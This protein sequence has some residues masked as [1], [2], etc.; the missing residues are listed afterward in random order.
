MDIYTLNNT[1]P[2]I[3]LTLSQSFLRLTKDYVGP[4][5][6]NGFLI[7]TNNNTSTQVSG[8]YITNTS[9]SAYSPTYEFKCEK[10]ST[11]KYPSGN[12]C[13]IL[14]G[15]N[16]HIFSPTSLVVNSPSFH[17]NESYSGIQVYATTNPSISLISRTNSG[18]QAIRFINSNN[19]IEYSICKDSRGIVHSS[20]DQISF[21]DHFR[22][23]GNYASI[24][25]SSPNALFDNVALSINGNMRV[26]DICASTCLFCGKTRF[27]NDTGTSGSALRTGVD[28]YTIAKFYCD[29]E[30][31][32]NLISRCNICTNYLCSSTDL[33]A[34][35]GIYGCSGFF[36]N[37]IKSKC[38]IFDSICSLS[39][40]SCFSNINVS[41]ITIS[42]SA[43]TSIPCLNITN[44]L[45]YS[46]NLCF[47]NRLDT[48]GI[49]I[50]ESSGIQLKATGFNNCLIL[51][52]NLNCVKN[53]NAQGTIT[54]DNIVTT[55]L[56]NCHN[57]F[58]STIGVRGD[59]TGFD[60]ISGVNTSHLHTNT[61]CIANS[62]T[63]N[64]LTVSNSFNYNG[65]IMTACS[66]CFCGGLYAGL[67]S[68]GEIGA[69]NSSKAWGV[70]AL[71]G[72]VPLGATGYNFSDVRVPGTGMFKTPAYSA[73]NTIA[74]FTC[75]GTITCPSI[76][77]FYY[78]FYG[79]RL[80]KPVR[81]PF[82]FSSTFMNTSVTFGTAPTGIVLQTS[83]NLRYSGLYGS[84]TVANPV[85]NIMSQINLV[86]CGGFNTAGNFC[87]NDFEQ[88]TIGRCYNEIIIN[89]SPFDFVACTGAYR[90]NANTALQGF[91]NGTGMFHIV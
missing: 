39:G 81:Y 36:E 45:G 87:S 52:G 55:G 15:S 84:G 63:T 46:G 4:Y 56:F 47:S 7:A 82:A 59:I 85:D 74:H 18:Q 8:L 21:N 11:I 40:T 88:F 24:G 75:T 13:L 42:S 72:G 58:Q 79:L 28:F 43:V 67:N 60:C 17:S 80:N 12:Y 71:S 30:A 29:I 68:S 90:Y 78:F 38:G 62:I 34:I 1:A 70:F 65:N 89:I 31:D 57:Y 3:S 66:G 14:T 35:S 6:G 69:I 16:S 86:N 64:N 48:S 73:Y 33:C 44:Q 41:G 27:F 20:S 49:Y 9:I 25:N 91:L 23:S 19:L 53:I 61:A 5:S 51:S 50:F 83:G 54:I 10:N 22:I 26:V 37:Q 32:S 77:G 2:E 76:S